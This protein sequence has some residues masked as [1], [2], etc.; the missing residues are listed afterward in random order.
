MVVDQ[1]TTSIA[2]AVEERSRVDAL[3]DVAREPAIS[4]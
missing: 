3:L 1:R 4:P 2:R